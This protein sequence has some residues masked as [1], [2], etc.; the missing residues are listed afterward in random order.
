MPLK[1]PD[2]LRFVTSEIAD[3]LDGDAMDELLAL[4][5]KIQSPLGY[6]SVL[7]TF[8][9]HFG[10]ATGTGSATS[11]SVD[12]AETD[13]WRIARD[14][15]NNAHSFISAFF[16]ACEQL[17]ETG[18]TVP[19]ESHI[20]AVLARY[21][22]RYLINEGAL[23]VSVPDVAPPK[24]P[25]SPDDAVAKAL[26]DAAA[27]KGQSG[28]ASAIDR[29]HTALHGYLRH[30]CVEDKITFPD[31]PTT[32]KLF[33]LLRTHH[34]TFQARGPRAKDISKIL[35]SFASAIDALSPIRNKASLAHANPLLDEPEA[36]AA[37]NAARTIFHYIQDCINRASKQ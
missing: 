10:R 27:L 37:L 17:Q 26:A 25:L 1:M 35:N 34:S 20:N 7:E 24:A 18:S 11:S 29:A 9:S 23:V 33:K 14:A 36:A 12:W 30:L 32:Q 13:F 21:G 16:D 5:K 28:A 31:N 6:E 4:A 3:T 15:A 19:G 8:K 2:E 22:C